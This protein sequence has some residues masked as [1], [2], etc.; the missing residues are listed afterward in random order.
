MPVGNLARAGRRCAA[1]WERGAGS[2]PTF[3]DPTQRRLAVLVGLTA[4]V[5][6]AGRFILNL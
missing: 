2:K 4:V 5:L 3:N 6:G 1:R